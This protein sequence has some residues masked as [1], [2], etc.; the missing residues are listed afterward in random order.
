M[1]RFKLVDDST[2]S[3]YF[4]FEGLTINFELMLGFIGGSLLLICMTIIIVVCVVTKAKP[5]SGKHITP[6]QPF[7]PYETLDKNSIRIR[8]PSKIPKQISSQS[9]VTQKL[10]PW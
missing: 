7:R 3:I 10:P 8:K 1:C 2:R 5:P 9:G 4:Y 6:V